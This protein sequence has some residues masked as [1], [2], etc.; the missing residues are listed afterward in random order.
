MASRTLGWQFDYKLANK[1]DCDSNI[2][3]RV[4]INFDTKTYGEKSQNVII[5]FSIT[6]QELNQEDAENIANSQAIKLT[7][8]LTASSGT[9]SEF[10]ATG[11]KEITKSGR[12]R[13]RT[14]IHSSY[15]IRNKAI[16]SMN[17]NKFQNI[18]NV[19]DKFTEKIHFISKARRAEKSKDFESIIKYLFQ[20]CNENPQGEL[21][22]FKFLRHAISHNKNELKN[23][24]MDELKK[25]FGENYFQLSGNKFDFESK[26]NIKNLKIQ[27][28]SFLKTMHSDLRQKLKSA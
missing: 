25:G 12:R 13:I 1:I 2:K 5:G 21:K 17:D 8:L 19:N 28:K 10:F 18:L 15:T 26:Q 9:H 3:D 14:S 24:T 16:L 23:L 6:S 7:Q 22:K 27:A 11:Y 20:A 4:N